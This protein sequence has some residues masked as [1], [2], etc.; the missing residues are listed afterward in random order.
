MTLDSLDV[1]RRTAGRSAII[2]AALLSLVALF[3]VSCTPAGTPSPVPSS[4][5]G[6]PVATEELVGLRPTDL[7]AGLQPSTLVVDGDRLVVAGHRGTT[8]A[9]RRPAMAV[10]DSGGARSIALTP[11]EPYAEVAD[12]FSVA[13]DGTGLQTLGVAHGGAHA[14]PRWTT[15]SGTTS[16]VVDHPQVFWTFGGEE[17]G[18]LVAIVATP[19]GPRIVGSWQGRTALDIAVWRPDGERWTR[20]D[21][22]GTP[23]ANTATLQVSGRSAAPT[24]A[25]MIVAGSVFDLS[26][27]STSSPRSGCPPATAGGRRCGCPI[28]GSAAR[29]CR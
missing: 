4:T 9:D 6:T 23:L 5:A 8:A 17:A 27:G 3:T 29:R 13:A 14:N 16:G 26:G 25:G 22:A 10:L 11:R 15:W 12:I 1:G 2:A 28:P 20:L 7:P 24:P 18:I 21:S 19:A